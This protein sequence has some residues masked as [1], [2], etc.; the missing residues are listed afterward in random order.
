MNAKHQFKYTYNETDYE[1]FS[2]LEVTFEMPAEVSLTQMLNN[3]E[4]YLR[5]CGF[6]FDGKLAIVEDGYDLPEEEPEYGCMADWDEDAFHKG[7]NEMAKKSDEKIKQ[8]VKEWNEGIAKLDKEI[9]EQREIREKATKSADALKEWNEGIAKLE[10]DL[11]AKRDIEQQAYERAARNAAVA[12]N[13]WVHGMCNP[14]S[15]D[16]KVKNLEGDLA[17]IVNKL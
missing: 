16:W 11:K 5:A 14:P 6:F 17:N 8:K 13:N 4:Q 7:L 1:E 12:K 2:P 3:F 9:K 15:P 10:N